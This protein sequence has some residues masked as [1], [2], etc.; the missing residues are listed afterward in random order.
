MS[1]FTMSIFVDVVLIMTVLAVFLL[2]ILF[3][4]HWIVSLIVILKDRRAVRLLDNYA[5]LNRMK[6]VEKAVYML[7][8]FGYKDDDSL[9][10]IMESKDSFKLF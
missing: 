3:L 7:R 4:S 6:A 8:S 10:S 5:R 2:V 9:S 1:N